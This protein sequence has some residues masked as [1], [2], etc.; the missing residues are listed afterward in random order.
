MSTFTIR[1]CRTL[2]LA[3]T[4]SMIAAA[5]AAGGGGVAP[6]DSGAPIGKHFDPLGQ[7]PSKFT[8]E[9]RNGIK[10]QLPFGTSATSTRRRK[11]SSPSRRTRR[12][13]RMPATSR[14]TWAA[15]SGC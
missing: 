3:V 13:W 7:P 15:T 1:A 10:A 9:L 12:S 6:T 2:T 14:G 5:H 8:I 4:I 11:A